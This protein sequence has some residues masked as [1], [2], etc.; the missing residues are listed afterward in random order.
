[1][2]DRAFE[3]W[4]AAIPLVTLVLLVGSAN[5]ENPYMWGINHLRYY[6][7]WVWIVSCACLLGA[8]YAPIRDRVIGF[9]VHGVS[10]T[11]GHIA[12]VFVGLATFV[13]LS[14]ATHLLGDGYLLTRE[15]EYGLRKSANEPLS[16]WLLDRIL[17]TVRD[18]GA[19][20]TDVY[21]AW[22]YGSGVC[23]L[24][25]LPIAA[26][27]LIPESPES[28]PELCLLL[29]L[30]TYS[31]LFFGYHETYPVLLPLLLL[32]VC[33]GFLSLQGQLPKWVPCLLL[34]FMASLHF[35]MVTV[36]LS[37]VL[38]IAVEGNQSTRVRAAISNAWALLPGAFLFI[39]L[40]QLTGFDPGD[41]WNRASG[42]TFLPMLGSAS[43]SIPYPA[44]SVPHLIEFVNEQLLVFLP[45]ILLFSFVDRTFLRS[46]ESVF[47]LSAAIPAW[48]VTFFGFTV[49]GAFRDWDALA[50]PALLT[51]LWVG[52]G[53]VRSSERSK[54]KSVLRTVGIAA[55][56]PLVLWLGI[57]ADPVRATT[58]FE[59]ALSHSSLSARARSFGWETLGAHFDSVPDREGAIR[60]YEN[61]IANAPR[62]PRYP[63]LLGYVL[64]QK[65]AFA[66]AADNFR[67]A[68]TLDPEKYQAHLNLG[69]SLV[70]LGRFDEAIAALQAAQN[71]RGDFA[72][73]PFALGVAFYAKGAYESAAQAYESAVA[74]DPSLVDAQLNL[75]KLYGLIGQE[76]LQY[77]Q[78]EIM[79]EIQPQHGEAASL[80]E[81]MAWFEA[82]RVN[83]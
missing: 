76:A 70:Q 72:K 64:M 60:S 45:T 28:T 25:L 35:M 77:R 78:F 27:R 36:S 59:D 18:L 43:H 80:R 67:A 81:W 16:L 42:E 66:H 54:V 22:S 23:F 47:L 8:A 79:L 51:T 6:P 30:P 74:L 10:S 7:V 63:N 11:A 61:A 71:L 19:S 21:S 62:H 32:Y 3:K 55:A 13:W 65:G 83:E 2:T 73:I 41:Y 57:N 39:G 37:A 24:I 29:L 49:I 9:S 68:I 56:I 15:L 46:R 4:L 12:L 48:V 52:I 26:R 5:L 20:S 75:G 1:M 34:G 40:L 58:R 31:Q 44:L 50:L 33:L 14:D 82:R 69:L 38:L 17:A 53:V